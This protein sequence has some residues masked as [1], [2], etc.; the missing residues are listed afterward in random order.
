MMQYMCTIWLIV[1]WWE[2]L[3]AKDPD[4]SDLFNKIPIIGDG[5][6]NILY[7]TFHFVLFVSLH[8]I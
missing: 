4:P 8:N 3:T 6:S 2:Q 5:Y 1:E 7:Y